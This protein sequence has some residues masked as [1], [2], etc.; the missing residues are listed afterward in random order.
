MDYKVTREHV[1]YDH[2]EHDGIIVD[3]L[4][5]GLNEWRSVPDIV[6]LT[7]KALSDVV[8]SHTAALRELEIQIATKAN[9]SELVQKANITD[10]N[11]AFSEV[12]VSS[13]TKSLD[14][15]QV[16][17]EEKASRKEC[18]YLI[19]GKFNELKAELDKKAEFREVQNEFRTLKSMVEDLSFKKSQTKDLDQV[20]KRLDEKANISDVNAALDDKV[21]K[22]S[23]SA[24]L[25]KKVNKTEIE[26][27]LLSKADVSEVQSVV[28][29][30][31]TK[32]DR[33]T[34]EN[35]SREI[36]QKIDRNDLIKYIRDEISKKNEHDGTDS[37]I[38]IKRD[39]DY[40]LNQFDK[41]LETL[42]VSIQQTQVTLSEEI[43]SKLSGDSELSKIASSMRAEVR[44]TEEKFSE[45]FL[46]TE[47]GIKSLYEEFNDMKFKL[48]SLLQKIEDKEKF[49]KEFPNKS[50]LESYVESKLKNI[51]ELIDSKPSKYEI[52]N[53]IS[54][55][56]L[57]RVYIEE[58]EHIKT[59]LDGISKKNLLDMYDL[60]DTLRN[61]MIQKVNTQDLFALIKNKPDLNEIQDLVAS[62]YRLSDDKVIIETL[63]SE[64]CIGRWL[65]KSG[66]LRSGFT[67]P[68]EIQSINTCPENFMWEKDTIS[69][70]AV[71]PGLYEIF[72]GFFASKKPLVQLL[73]NGETVLLDVPGEGKVWGRHRDGNIIGATTTEYIALPARARL[74]ISYSGPKTA[75]GFLSLKKL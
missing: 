25:H 32:V 38:R 40:K 11:R 63:C 71:S 22:Q 74:C 1:Y 10:L 60:I 45:K 72:F 73:V 15:F 29:I 56:K 26:A 44:K 39:L 27:L 65:W 68:W 57:N 3:E 42:K 12:R 48:G 37:V 23:I 34:I 4:L 49:S 75:E 52:S 53:L 6:R 13:E 69:I 18:Q 59:S 64:N 41:Y 35:F 19:N 9:R 28:A 50:Y 14:G 47:S 51:I 58:I 66:D 43:A 61:D 24:A 5:N 46:R 36:A 67:V 2:E 16:L 7:F 70:V 55:S 20:Y 21:S 8:K 54:E 31:D 17:L 33:H 30:L 62:F